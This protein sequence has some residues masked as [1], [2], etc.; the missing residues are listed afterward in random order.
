MILG[1][2]WILVNDH[3]R[4]LKV[5]LDVKIQHDTLK[6]NLSGDGLVVGALK[7]FK[8]IKLF[9]VFATDGLPGQKSSE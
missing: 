9:I 4:G 3:L 1:W 7:K 6:Q 8:K 2:H 5:L